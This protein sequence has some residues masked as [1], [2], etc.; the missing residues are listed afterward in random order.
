MDEQNTVR[1]QG[2]T[3]M[4][5]GGLVALC[6][7]FFILGMVVGRSQAPA[8]DAVVEAVPAA[9]PAP[10]EEEPELEF[11]EALTQPDVSEAPSAETAPSP[12]V[13]APIEEVVPEVVAVPDPPEIEEGGLALQL[14]AFREEAAADGLVAEVR[15]QGFQAFVLRPGSASDLHRVQ[16]GPFTS[17]DEASRVR[18]Q[19]E[20]AGWTSIIVR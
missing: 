8:V 1:G 4:V 2:F 11:Y 9:Q 19:L 7:V 18:G 13:P 20:A 14:G 6:S 5:F 15:D 12:S 17:E 16:V 10:E 3:L